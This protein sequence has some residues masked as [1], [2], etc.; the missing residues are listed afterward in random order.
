[1]KPNI[2]FIVI[3]SL[4]SDR[5]YGNKKT[6]NTPN[7]DFLIEKGVYCTKAISSTDY[8][9]SSLQ[10]IFTSRY[11][12]GCGTTK[13]NYHKIY[14]QSTSLFTIL[15][16]NDYHLYAILEE[17]I[18]TWGLD[19]PF[20]NDDVAFP[21][22]SNLYNGL[23]EVILKKFD[24][25]NM[26][27][28]WFYCV[29]LMDL[30]KSN[31]MPSEFRH[32][33]QSQKYDQNLSS[34]DSWI[35]KMLEKNNFEN[36]LVIVTADHGDYLTSIDDSIKTPNPFQKMVKS[37]IKRMIPTSLR[38]MVH[39][40]K[41][42]TINQIR[43]AKL[44]TPHEKRGF[45]TRPMVDRF[46][47]D[48]VVNVPLIFSGYGLKNQIISQQVRSIDIFPTMFD[49][50]G[51]ENRIKNIHGRSFVGLLDG[52]KLEKMPAYLETTVIETVTVAPKAVIGIRTDEYKY[53]RSIK[54]PKTNVHLYD[55]TN[56]PFEDHNIAEKHPKKVEEF[57]NILE[58]IRKETNLQPEYDSL[59]EDEEKELEDQLRKLGYI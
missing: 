24:P 18:C 27:E 1:M 11:P 6:A 29:D 4:R 53:F 13:E 28:P 33:T 17:A 20:E 32:L 22:S 9:S 38:P 12:L 21:A 16:E 55:L 37:S 26:K 54:D 51:L 41:L 40:K 45:N 47:F 43:A 49:I 57:E 5:C 30:H 3:D 2:L 23:G 36:T 48:D 46:L 50:I 19:E 31:P 42:D 35:G 34:I 10:S 56:D 8:T 52:K 59:N 7:I 25:G 58:E 14:S 44:K 39:Q 15:Q